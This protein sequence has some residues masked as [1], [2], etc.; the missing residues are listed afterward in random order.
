M[1]SIYLVARCRLRVYELLKADRDEI[2]RQKL[3]LA[4]PRQPQTLLQLSSTISEH[5]VPIFEHCRHKQ[6]LVTVT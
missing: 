2:A 5:F 3:R 1:I 4:S 6:A